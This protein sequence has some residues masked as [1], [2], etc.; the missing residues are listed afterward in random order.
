MIKQELEIVAMKEM[1]IKLFTIQEVREFVSQVVL[2]EF[3]VDLIQG[4]YIIDAKSI[5]G[6]FSLDLLSPIT[7]RI[8]SD[9][10]DEFLASIAS[11]KA[12]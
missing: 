3:D 11:F 8:H 7:V 5:M 1:K 4:R 10:A 6:I 2:Q 9:N 12:E